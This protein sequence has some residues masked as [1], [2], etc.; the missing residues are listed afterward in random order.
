M[1]GISPRI[2]SEFTHYELYSRVVDGEGYKGTVLYIGGVAAAKNKEEIWLGIKWDKLD[3]GKHDGSCSDENGVVHRYF[4]C[5]AGTGSFVKPSKVSFGISL[6]EALQQRYVAEDAP[7][8]AD[9]NILPDAF[10]MTSKGNQKSI[11]LLGEK[12]IRRWQQI[13]VVEKVSLREENISS[14]G[15]DLFTIA[16]HFKEIDLQDNLLY[17]WSE[18]SFCS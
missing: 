11:E 6:I 5:Q 3:R 14:I 9:D 10:V 13:D 2:M 7:V 16:G 17:R 18:V 12:K 8:I 1:E 15:S 4:S